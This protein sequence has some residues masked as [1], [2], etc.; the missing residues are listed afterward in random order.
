MNCF[1]CFAFNALAFHPPCLTSLA[2]S[3]DDI[4]HRRGVLLLLLHRRRHSLAHCSARLTRR[5][6]AAAL[7]AGRCR[8]RGRR[9]WPCRARHT[10]HTIAMT[11][12]PADVQ[13][14]GATMHWV[15]R[16]NTCPKAAGSCRTSR[17][18]TPCAQTSSAHPP[19]ATS[20]HIGQCLL[21]RAVVCSVRRGASRYRV[22]AWRGRCDW[23]RAKC[24]S[25]QS[26]H[27]IRLVAALQK[28]C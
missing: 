5:G 15:Q 27:Q 8:G 2:A 18:H 10:H 17:S 25:G 9:M 11:A 16:Q 28:T 22:L 19:H 21:L 12:S 13:S 7:P 20:L 1:S 3:D 4:V 23:R 24:L 26:C 14:L 6:P